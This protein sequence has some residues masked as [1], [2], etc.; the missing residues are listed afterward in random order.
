MTGCG[1]HHGPAAAGVIVGA[2]GGHQMVWIV[3]IVAVV[4]AAVAVL[5]IR[6][7]TG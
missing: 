3:A 4:I 1:N 5:P 7:A 6:Q 2:S